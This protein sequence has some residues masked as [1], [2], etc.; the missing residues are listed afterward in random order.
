[1]TVS[2]HYTHNDTP[3]FTKIIKGKMGSYS[4]QEEIPILCSNDCDSDHSHI[5]KRN[6]QLFKDIILINFKKD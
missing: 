2:N 6:A 4:F 1:M 3:Y 5:I